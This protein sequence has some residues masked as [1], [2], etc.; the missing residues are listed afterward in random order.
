MASPVVVP[1][2]LTVR[3]TLRVVGGLALPV[4]SVGDT[5]WDAS[6]PLDYLNADHLFAP[7]FSQPS[8]T[9]ATNV[10]NQPI[11]VAAAAGQILSVFVGSVVACVGAA[12]IVVDVKKNGT[13]VLTGTVTLD[14]A[15]TAYIGESGTLAGAGAP[16]LAAGDVITVSVTAT[17]GGG[18]L[19]QGVFVRVRLWEAAS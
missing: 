19:G 4:D 12:T 2:D 10:T 8:G 7:V 6:D 9:A 15:N 1:E 18:T 16:T 13:T 3:G 11:H 17:A 14:S 5:E